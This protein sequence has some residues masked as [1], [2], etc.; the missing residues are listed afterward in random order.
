MTPCGGQNF[1]C[2]YGATGGPSCGNTSAMFKI[3]QLAPMVLHLLP[4]PNGLCNFTADTTNCVPTAQLAVSNSSS[5]SSANSSSPSFANSTL[6]CPSKSS[7]N[8]ALGVGLGIPLGISVLGC[9]GLSMLLLQKNARTP[10]AFAPA[11]NH[12]EGHP[13]QLEARPSEIDSKHGV[14]E[15]PSRDVYEAPTS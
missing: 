15:L 2:G 8:V 3:A 14:H 7:Q 1:V 10:S 13:L 11:Y 6:H 12:G 9:V 5:P 4:D